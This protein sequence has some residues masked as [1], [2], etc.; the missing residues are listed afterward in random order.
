MSFDEVFNDKTKN[1]LYCQVKREAVSLAAD[2]NNSIPV[3]GKLL[4]AD[5]SA[6]ISCERMLDFI[7]ANDRC[8]KTEM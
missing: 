8:G 4:N 1:K 2:Q 3:A 5:E 7:A 6:M